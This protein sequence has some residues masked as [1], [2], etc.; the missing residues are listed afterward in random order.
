MRKFFISY[1][2]SDI[3]IAQIISLVIE[4]HGYITFTDYTKMASERDFAEQITS[5]IKE[6]DFV[7]FIASKSSL[8]SEYRRREIEYATQQGKTII[9]IL[10]KVS[11]D[12][13]ES[14]W[15]YNYV[16]ESKWINWD[17]VIELDSFAS[18]LGTV[19][20]LIVDIDE[21]SD[22][23]FSWKEELY[24]DKNSFARTCG[25]G[26]N[27]NPFSRK[28]EP[29]TQIS[30]NASSPKQLEQS[31]ETTYSPSKTKAR[32]QVTDN[33][34]KSSFGVGAVLGGIF[35]GIGGIFSGISGLFTGF[36]AGSA[37]SGKKK[38]SI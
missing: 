20:D 12:E 7:L 24:H 30:P 34:P 28:N 19:K 27:F 1:S 37:I 16:Q 14:S 10:Y 11:D 13:L 32:P 2:R 18:T 31:K 23:S 4:K 3:T 22:S 29:P 36:A 38:K 35:S 8:D 5:F 33:A 15:L 25:G 9:P 21:Q 26:T 17:N 6:S